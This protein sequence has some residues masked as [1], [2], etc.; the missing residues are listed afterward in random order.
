MQTLPTMTQ[1]SAPGFQTRNPHSLKLLRFLL[2]LVVITLTGCSRGMSV[3]SPAPAETFS[4]SVQNQ[5]GVTMVVSY[6]DGRGDAILGTVDA[7]GTE[8]F[9]IAAPAVQT[10]TVRGAAT[11]G[12]RSSGPHSVTLVA[13]TTQTVRLR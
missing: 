12:S 8:R 2:L 13:G 6:N 10:I 1:I 5:T 3:G 4:I 11:S 7:G 9:I